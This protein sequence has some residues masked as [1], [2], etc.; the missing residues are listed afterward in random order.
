MRK[1]NVSII[2]G[3]L[4]ALTAAC[5]AFGDQG[6]R[7]YPAQQLGLRSIKSV[8]DLSDTRVVVTDG[9]GGRI[10][11]LD[12][13]A[14]DSSVPGKGLSVHPMKLDLNPYAAVKPA[15]TGFL[16][17][18]L[19]EESGLPQR[20]DWFE[21]DLSRRGEALFLQKAGNEDTEPAPVEDRVLALYNWTVTGDRVFAY[22]AL[23]SGRRDDLNREAAFKLGFFTFRLRPRGNVNAVLRGEMIETSR[24]AHYYL[25]GFPYVVADGNQC[26]FVDMG[27]TKPMLY[28]YNVKV[29]ERP[30]PLKGFPGAD[31]QFLPNININAE[32][33]ATF[34]KIKKEGPGL[35]S[36]L[37]ISDLSQE[38]D[39]GDGPQ[40]GELSK[41][42][43]DKPK[44]VALFLLRRPLSD[45]AEWTMTKLIPDTA[46][47]EVKAAGSIGLG[48]KAPFVTV[49]FTETSILV[50][51]KSSVGSKGEQD[52]E[53]LWVYPRGMLESLGRASRP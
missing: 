51:E 46:G 25:L 43:D 13:P 45:Q 40:G 32:G 5:A 30:F 39:E 27:A 23:D 26:Y 36:G 48:T 14:G 28:Y 12:L 42:R 18:I 3:I 50:F 20:I 47:G 35:P 7:W 41:D 44:P 19:S 9:I 1:T 16:Q 31:D 29:P 11:V 4:L 22:G 24:E 38:D 34:A 49:H 52:V 6:G 21:K 2:A 17:V 33:Y 53:G 37:F 10:V 15:S 8:V